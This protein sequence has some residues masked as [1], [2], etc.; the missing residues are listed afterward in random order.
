MTEI[1]E[2]QRRIECL[3]RTDRVAEKIA[4]VMKAHG[5]GT[6]SVEF[7]QRFLETT[8]ALDISRYENLKER[9]PERQEDVHVPPITRRAQEPQGK[10]VCAQCGLRFSGRVGAVYCSTKC[11]MRHSRANKQALQ[12]VAA[13]A[14][15][16]ALQEVAALPSQPE[17]PPKIL[18][19]PAPDQ[20]EHT[21]GLDEL[22]VPAAYVAASSLPSV[23]TLDFVP[24]AAETKQVT[25]VAAEETKDGLV[26]TLSG[27][28]SSETAE[29][30]GLTET[31]F[32]DLAVLVPTHVPEPPDTY[33]TL[34][35]STKRRKRSVRLTDKEREL[36]VRLGIKS[37]PAATP[38]KY[39]AR[40][41]LDD[42]EPIKRAGKRSYGPSKNMLVRAVAGQGERC[43][44]CDRLFGALVVVDGGFVALKAEPEHFVPRAKRLNNATSNIVAACQICNGLKSSRL[45]SSMAQART[46]LQA[47]WVERGWHDAPLLPMPSRLTPATPYFL[48][49]RVSTCLN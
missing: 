11:R 29:S 32:A 7:L 40:S 45:F 35:V 14:N 25:A 33:P 5:K 13:R 24:L 3:A 34:C 26:D 16:Q 31:V 17:P 15:K 28:S 1:D 36:A 6:F 47:A 38:P 42:F 8:T 30:T 44:Y 39:L 12:E 18:P 21:A 23:P 49:L 27:K 4:A 48:A 37:L 2:L 10:R 22:A 43:A 9:P 20:E 46:V 19:Q 41:I